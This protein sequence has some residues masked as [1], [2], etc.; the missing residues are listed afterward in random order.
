M[1][2]RSP[3]A[4]GQLTACTDEHLAVTAVGRKQ[5]PGLGSE[6]EPSYSWSKMATG[7]L[8][9]VTLQGQT[10]CSNHFILT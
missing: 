9:A 6:G 3:T 4:P 7:G 10:V 5:A 1:I 8:F 2:F